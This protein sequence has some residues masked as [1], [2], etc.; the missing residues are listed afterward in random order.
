MERL[1]PPVRTA[2]TASTASTATTR[3][4]FLRLAGS[5]A[6]FTALARVPVV[7]ASARA[8]AEAAPVAGGGFFDP[9]S[10]EILTRVV[11]R[12]VDT[13]EPDAPAV[14]DTRTIA[15]IDALCAGLDPALTEPLPWLLWLVEW[16]PFVFDLS[17]ARFTRMEPAARDASLRGW[18]TSRFALRRQG[19]AALRNLA[20]LGYYTQEETWPLIGY[21]G[22][23]LRADARPA[24]PGPVLPEEAP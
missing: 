1:P 13:G 5:T 23:L 15:T 14:G 21:A 6:A 7:P 2:S 19:F 3:R 22:P 20:F 24:G 8:A 17:F 12:L 10:T 16:G 9:D 18:M 11:E 4:G